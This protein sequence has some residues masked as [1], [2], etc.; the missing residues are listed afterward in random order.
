MKTQFDFRKNKWVSSTTDRLPKHDL[1]YGTPVNHPT[2]GIPIGDGDTG[3]LVWFEK[4]GIH[5]NIWKTDLWQ[6]AIPGTTYDDVCYCSGWEECHTVQKHGGELKIRFDSPLFDYMYQK[7][8]TARLSLTDATAYFSN[9]TP[10]GSVNAEF[11]ASGEKNVSALRCK[12]TS[13]EGE[14]PEIRLAR[15]GS[16]TLWRWYAKQ[17][18]A[19]EI[20]LDGTDVFV[21]DDRIY[22]THELNAT[23]FCLALAMVSK[24]PIRSADRKNSHEGALSLGRETEHEFTLY[25]TIRIA[26]NTQEAKKLCEKALD[27]A[28]SYGWEKLHE[29]HKKAWESFWNKSHIKIADDYMEN[30]YYLFFY[31]MNSES[32]GAYPPHFTSGIWGFF[33]DHLPWTYYFHYNMQHLYA[34]LDAAG[35]G[36]LS[37]NYLKM[38]RDG[39]DTAYKYGDIAKKIHGA[40]YHDVCDRYSRGA[41]YHMLNAACGTLI[42][43]QMYKHYRYTGDE[44]YLTE[45]ALPVMRGTAEYYLN[46]LKKDENGVYHTSGTTNYE[47]S[48]PMNDTITD[49]TMIKKMFPILREY[50]EPELKAKLDDVLENIADYETVPLSVGDDWDGEVFTNGVG[51]GKPP[52]GKGHV[53]SIGYDDDGV[54][55]RKTYGNGREPHP[56]IG[57][58][59]FPEVEY[60]LLYPAGILGLNDRGSYLFECM[61]NQ[62]LLNGYGTAHWSMMTIFHAR[63]GMADEFIDA[64]HNIIKERQHFVNGFNVESS[65]E[66][67]TVGMYLEPEN[68]LT[69]KQYLLRQDDFIHFDFETVPVITQGITD[70]LLQSHEGLIRICPAVRPCDDA[71]FSL[72][73]EGG[74]HVNAEIT[75][76]SYLVS[77]ENLRGESLYIRLPEYSDLSVLR[78]YVKHNGEADFTPIEHKY[79]RRGKEDLLDF[80]FT[81]KGDIVLLLSESIDSVEIG[82]RIKEAPNSEMKTL[83]VA[84]L[85]LPKLM[86]E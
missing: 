65:G 7:K 8:Y 38:R 13:V 24:N 58:V 30:L 70:T 52:I 51:K 48:F 55:Y 35:H 15:W 16:R 2:T 73:G 36:E 53:F 4:D 69:G 6:D 27:D 56:T 21:E 17:K 63:L 74:F 9:E 22:I 68:T 64:A 72:Y 86:E 78:A 41:D 76:D 10:L 46:I 59:S 25:Y 66:F 49:K 1:Y 43:L 71:S 32:R 67:P 75:A 18:F 12:I 23:K 82:E 54:R 84:A 81:E 26:E 44:K 31:Y 19:P 37:H 5:I 57:D 77:V 83:G 40:F 62:A 3:S 11:F 28:I 14:A 29:D 33:H 34:P 60:S 79:V 85:G 20:G 47:A 61:Q 80:S 45:Y 50:A 42:S 39:L